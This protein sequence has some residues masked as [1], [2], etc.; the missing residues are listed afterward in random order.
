MKTYIAGLALVLT[1]PVVADDHVAIVEQAFANISN[2]YHQEWAFTESV[3]EDG[4]TFVG[5]YDP[6]L[7]ENARWSLLT[8]DGREPT[9]EES[10]EFQDDRQDEFHDDDDDN[11]IDIVDVDTLKL[12]EET[13]EYWLFRF[14]PDMDDDEDDEA[15]KFMQQ[16]DGTVKIIRDGNYLEYI[17]MR[18][19]KPIR[20]VF[21]VKF[22]RFLTRLTFGP[23]GGEG[24][25]VPLSIDVE[26]RGRAMLVIKIDERESVH[27][28]DYE[29]VGS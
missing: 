21:G 9:A 18:N 5:R 17:D 14:I 13:D 11:E 25:I 26:V 27:Y 2:D 12:V 1:A 20:P 22:S 24:P 23:A 16:V 28:D 29:Y 8:V 6:R 15:Q 3:I 7:P 4:V 10:D 19:K